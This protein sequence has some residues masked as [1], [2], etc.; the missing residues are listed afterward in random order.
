MLQILKNIFLVG[1][2]GCSS[3]EIQRKKLEIRAPFDGD[4]F[5]NLEPFPD[6]SLFTVLR[7]RFSRMFTAP[8]WPDWVETSTLRPPSSSS[9]LKISL[10]NHATIL[11]QMDGINI[12]TDPIYSQRSSVVSFAGPKRIHSPGIQFEDLPVIHAVLVSHNHY[13]HLDVPTLKLLQKR[14]QPRIFA[15]LGTKGFLE[16][17][18]I[19]G[20]IDLD[21]WEETQLFGLSLTFVPAQHWSMR[22]TVD[23]RSMLWGGYYIKGSENVYFAGD[24]GYGKFFSAIRKKL[25]SPDWALLPIGAYEPRWFMKHSH[26]NPMEAVQA[27]VDLGTKRAM[28]MHF[29]TFSNLAD[30]GYL[31]PKRDLER[32]LG[33][34]GL[35]KD[36]FLYPKV[37]VLY[38]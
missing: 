14:D 9:D 37:G 17:E 16:A 33:V 26:M 34:R 32:A 12:L 27:G 3:T 22:A 4:V 20:A 10:I 30:E 35:A 28:G 36:W 23:R 38:P 7:W 1:L 21:W 29:G 6:K 2:L 8:S 19:S 15:G 5:D 11:I 13:D 31:Q 25:G 18:G 24:T